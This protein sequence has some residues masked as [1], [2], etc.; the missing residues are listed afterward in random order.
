MDRGSQMAQID[1]N[2]DVFQRRLGEFMPEHDG[3]LV[4]L[5]DGEV[6]GFFKTVRE[7]LIEAGRRFPDG[8]YSVQEVTTEPI[9]LGVFSHAG[10]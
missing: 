8:S 3:E 5:H 1:R 6:V 10:S 2:Y 4:L 7:V 9:D